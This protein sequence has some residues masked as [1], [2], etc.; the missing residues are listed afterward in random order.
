MNKITF[1]FESTYNTNKTVKTI[2]FTSWTE[3]LT[4]F[5]YFLK[6]EGFLVNKEALQDSVEELVNMGAIEDNEINGS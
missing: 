6:G 2:K 5:M 3:A 4:Q 1:I